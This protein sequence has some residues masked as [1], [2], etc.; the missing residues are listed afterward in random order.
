MR[1]NPTQMGENTWEH[2]FNTKQWSKKKTAI[3]K[4]KKNKIRLNY[5]LISWPEWMPALAVLWRQE[6]RSKGQRLSLAW[7]TSQSKLCLLSVSVL[8]KWDLNLPNMST[9]RPPRAPGS[10]VPCLNF[11][12]PST[13]HPLAKCTI[14][15]FQ[16]EFLSWI[17][18]SSPAIV[19]G[20]RKSKERGT[21]SQLY[22]QSL[23]HNLA[24]DKCSVNVC[25]IN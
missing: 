19:E 20:A 8:E 2:V 5:V 12:V 9:R 4:K 23:Q 25:W 7:G 11:P 22:L 17:P 16:A 14:F 13:A 10:S 24:Y 3:Y 1:T 15:M 18:S 21:C 6:Q